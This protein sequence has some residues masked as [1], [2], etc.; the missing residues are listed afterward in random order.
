MMLAGR[1]AYS[2][3]LTADDAAAYWPACNTF[4]LIGSDELLAETQALWPATMRAFRSPVQLAA[5]SAH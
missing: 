1:D 3:S 5:F 4:A 2:F